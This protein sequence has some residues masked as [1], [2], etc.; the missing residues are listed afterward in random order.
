MLAEVTSVATPTS[1]TTPAV[2]FSNS[3][4]GTLSVGGSCGSASEGAVGTGNIPITLTQPDNATPLTAGSYSDCTLTV[5]DGLGNTSNVL[6]LTPFVIDTLAPTVNTNAGITLDEGSNSNIVSSVQLSSTDNLS[7]A[8][9]VV[10]TLVSTTSNGALR[11]SGSALTGGATFTQSDINSN[12]ITYDHNGSE[13]TSDAFIFTIMDQVGNVNN[14][15][16]ANFTFSFT[17]TGVNDDP[18]GSVTIS[19]TTPAE[20][21]LLTA[22]NTLADVDGLGPFT[23]QWKRGVTNVGTNSA[24]YTPTQSDVNSM[25]TVTISYIDGGTNPESVTSAPTSAVTNVNNLPTG[26]V[27]INNLAPA[28]GDTLIASNT[29]ADIDGLGPFTYQWKSG[30]TD[31]GTNSA[32]YVLS[33]SDVGNAMTVAI[34]YTDGGDTP[35][36]KTS[37]ATAA[38]TNVNNA[39]NR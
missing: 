24:T 6:A 21:Q 5:D 28:E 12:F 15:A 1:N 31:V 14:N 38:V 13:T 32:S 26:N 4:A 22:N 16:A 35:E 17:I 23:Y 36:S 11:K 19:D 29:L 30:V 2:T 3:K 27:T 9:N 34:S 37:G 25:L 20:G 39:A 33:Q 10:Y 8:A 7:G 18:T